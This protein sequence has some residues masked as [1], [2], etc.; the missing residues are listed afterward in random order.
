MVV[1]PLCCNIS[2]NRYRKFPSNTNIYL[3]YCTTAKSFSPTTGPSSA[4]QTKMLNKG[5]LVDGKFASVH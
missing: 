4:C 5:V 1:I 3:F 2:I